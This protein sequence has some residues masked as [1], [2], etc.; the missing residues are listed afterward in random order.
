M[1]ELTVAGLLLAR[2]GDDHP[3]LLFEDA[4]WT[5]AE[6]VAESTARGRAAVALRRP[7]PFHVGVLLDNV[8]EYLW[9]IGG[10]ALAGAVV[11]GINPTRR[12]AELAADI[13]HTDC[14]LLVTDREHLPLLD[15][16]D[17]GVAPDRVLLVDAPGYGEVLAGGGGALDA[18]ADPAANHLLLFTS[19]SSGAP[20]AVVCTQGRLAGAGVRASEAFEVTRDDVCYQS[21]PLFHGNALMANWAPALARGAT[22][23]LRRKFSASGFL[24]DVRRFGATYFNYVGRALAYVLATPEGADDADNPLRTGF[25]TEASARDRERFEARFGCR[26]IE[27]YGS[28]EGVISMHRPPGSPPQSMGVVPEG[29]DVAVVDASGREC[30]RARF[31]ERGALV[32]GDEAIGELVRRD[33]APAFEGYYRNDAANEDRLRGGWYWSGDLAYRDADGY[34][35]FAGRGSDWLRVDSENFAAAPVERILARFPEVVMVAVYPVPD[36][37]TG[38]RVMAALEMEPGVAFD[39]DAFGRF[40][41]T[42]ADLG[43]KWAPTF[44]RIV[45]T[46]PLTA[47]NKVAKQPLRA[48]AWVS[49]DP[50]WWRTGPDGPYRRLTADDAAR[51]RQELEAEGRVNLLAPG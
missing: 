10:A 36:P 37:R 51:I 5:W 2:A 45:G 16:L 4:S 3:G 41:A 7:G 17:T 23:A 33:G 40:L 47:T 6:A 15:G 31:D 49:E 43:T 13:R 26:L 46:M 8:P 14:Q 28:S 12:G 38:D 34:F 24:P 50:V 25:G 27:S 21:M 20:K 29:V 22:V 32:N 39:P 30:P 9:W 18:E 48:E 42:Q 44:V 35:Y 11:V 19:G 1:A